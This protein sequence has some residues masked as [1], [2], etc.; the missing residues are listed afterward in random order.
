MHDVDIEK[1]LFDIR[2]KSASRLFVS[3][4]TVKHQIIELPED[5]KTMHRAQKQDLALLSPQ[6]Q[7]PPRDTFSILWNDISYISLQKS[8]SIYPTRIPR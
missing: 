4:E 8:Q 3:E 2:V 1:S 5:F 7:Q 6:N